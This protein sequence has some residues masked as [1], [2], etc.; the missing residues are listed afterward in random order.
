MLNIQIVNYKNEIEVLKNGIHQLE[1]K[2]VLLKSDNREFQDSAI[3]K[4]SEINNKLT[5]TVATLSLI[6]K[7]E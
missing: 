3:K 7:N 6:Q 2:I 5:I 1:E 4:V